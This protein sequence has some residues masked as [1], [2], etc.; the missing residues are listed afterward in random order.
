MLLNQGANP[1]ATVTDVTPLHIAAGLSEN[2]LVDMMLHY[3][4]NPN[5]R[6]VSF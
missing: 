3:G 4:G 6:Q 1:N 5:F 2:A